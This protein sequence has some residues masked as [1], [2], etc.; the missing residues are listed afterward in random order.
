MP[1]KCG[2]APQKMM[3]LSEETFVRNGVRDQSDIQWYSSV[4][5]MFPNCKKYADQLEIVRSSK[6]ITANFQHLIQRVDKDNR[7]VYFKNLKNN[8]EIP[9][10]YDF[11]HVVPPQTAPQF[12]KESGLAAANG[13]V[14]VD[15]GTLRH[16]KYQ[17]IF[18]LGDS[19]NLATAKTAAGVFSQAPIVVNNILRSVKK[20]NLN[21]IYDGYQSCPV[22][23]GDKKLM[24]IE[25]KYNNQPA[26]T[27]STNQTEP[28]HL[29]YL[30]KKEVFPRVYFNLAPRG[31]WFG[32]TGLVRPDFN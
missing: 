14:D 11:L 1:I 19:A 28:N 24:L 32:K 26:E 16:T 30:L 18:S 9:V 23:V 13:F 15:Q 25:F 22:F 20:L 10:D 12:I 5:D 31:R 8:E 21:G 17:N 29:F 27:F 6:G 4:G 7:R 2:G 3:Y